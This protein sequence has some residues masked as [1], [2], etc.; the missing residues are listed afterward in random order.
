MG[1]L[2]AQSNMISELRLQLDQQISTPVKFH[3]M[4]LKAKQAKLHEVA[5]ARQAKM[6]KGQKQVCLT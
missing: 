6:A 3:D 4:E 2:E 5:A 1:E